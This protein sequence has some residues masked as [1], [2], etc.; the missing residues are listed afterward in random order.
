MSFSKF[1]DQKNK[2]FRIIFFSLGLFFIIVASVIF[3]STFAPVFKAEINYQLTKKK[4]ETTGGELVE[5]I[6]VD[7]NFSIIIPKINANTK[8]I[9]NVNPFNSKIY[10]PALTQGVAHAKNTSTPDQSGN[11][12]IFAHSAGNWYQANQ[13]NAVFYLLNKL[14]IGDEIIVFYQSQ[15]YTYSVKETKLVNSNELNYLSTKTNQK[16]LTLMTCWPPGTTLNRLIVIAN[17]K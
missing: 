8:V 12:F 15:K 6:P 5:S 2:Y 9:K 4:I 14:K 7:P 11:T 13:F 16:Q 17:Q 3:L 1:V 10:Q